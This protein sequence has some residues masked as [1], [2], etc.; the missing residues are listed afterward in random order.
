MRQF[1]FTLRGPFDVTTDT[2]ESIRPTVNKEAALLAILA[3]SPNYRRSRVW[4]RQILWGD[5]SDEQSAA[6]LRQALSRLRKAPSLYREFL[7][8]DNQNVWL[9]SK[10]VIFHSAKGSER[11][12]LLEGMDIRDEMFEDW[13]LQERAAAESNNRHETLTP[14]I[15]Q[16]CKPA[17][18]ITETATYSDELHTQTLGAELREQLINVL[19]AHGLLD[20]VDRQPDFALRGINCAP[21]E[22]PPCMI[23]QV[24]L[25]T[26]GKCTR[27]SIVGRKTNSSQLSIALHYL[28]DSAL[29]ESKLSRDVSDLICRV[30]DQIHNIALNSPEVDSV[31]ARVYSAVQQLMSHSRQGHANARQ[32]L[33]RASIESNHSV[34]TA[35][36]AFSYAIGMGE[37]L[38][39]VDAG[40]NKRVKQLC[41]LAVTQDP[42][43]PVTRA[44]VGHVHSFVFRDLNTA[45]EHLNLAR[46]LAPQL[47]MA[48]DFASMHALYGGDAQ[49]GYNYASHAVRL[50]AFSPMKPYFDV[51][52]ALCAS[53][54]GKH[55]EALAVSKNVLTVM[56]NM[57]PVMRHMVGSLAATGDHDG[58]I[59]MIQSVT[60]LDPDFS[61]EN[62]IDPGYPLQSP[63]SIRV[64]RNGFEV[65]GLY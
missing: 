1:Y 27:V 45:A 51:S 35:W 16:V 62:V 55:H 54:V 42:F 5:R 23:I 40:F 13:L 61:Y 36:C 14:L 3:L 49:T 18:E 57:L 39:K 53:A 32:Y 64:I 63:D 65:V 29:E 25:V 48:W 15:H 50:G 56:P 4:L 52:I 22:A 58:A 33:E 37:R 31:S 28:Y 44:L 21:G 60:T 43:N 6:S 12:V 20:I 11:L 2:G 7:H 59:K 38:E 17:I 30:V 34:A 47:A 19:Y 10:Q 46:K 8:A 26:L 9:N 24:R 41:H